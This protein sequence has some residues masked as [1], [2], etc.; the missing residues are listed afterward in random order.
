MYLAK[1]SGL[2]QNVL[3]TIVI[4]LCEK[5]LNSMAGG[6]EWTNSQATGTAV[7]CAG[8]AEHDPGTGRIRKADDQVTATE[9]EPDLSGSSK[10]KGE[11]LRRRKTACLWAM[12]I[13][14][15]FPPLSAALGFILGTYVRPAPE[16]VT[17]KALFRKVAA[18]NGSAAARGWSGLPG[19]ESEQH[20]FLPFS[21]GHS[22]GRLDDVPFGWRRPH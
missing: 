8:I 20:R 14:S 3:L 21:G 11:V 4:L 15:T 16:K 5:N 17:E 6:N 10:E 13:I 19:L 2:E 22:A 1:S 12:H 7:R 9:R 18:V